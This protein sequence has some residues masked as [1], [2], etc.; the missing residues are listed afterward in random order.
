MH[1]GPSFRKSVKDLQEASSFHINSAEERQRIQQA[2]YW[3]HQTHFLEKTL[4][5]GLQW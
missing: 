2:L 1:I 4:K 5:L 3:V